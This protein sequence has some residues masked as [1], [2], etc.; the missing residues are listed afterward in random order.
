ME[1]FSKYAGLDAHKEA[2]AMS[3]AD[4]SGGRARY[5]GEVS[6]AN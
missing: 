3:V 1:K 6:V 4:A 2:I 5:L